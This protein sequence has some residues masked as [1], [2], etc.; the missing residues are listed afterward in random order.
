MIAISAG[1][2]NLAKGAY[3]GDFNEHDEAVVWAQMLVNFLGD[4][5]LLV[6][7]GFLKNKVSYINNDRSIVLAVEIHFNSAPGHV[8]RGSE[9]LCYPSSSKGRHAA[10]TVQDALGRIFQPSRGVKEG[11]YRMDPAR[12]PDFFLART[13]CTA[14]I[15]EPEF[16]HHE[17]AI[18]KNREVACQALTGALLE[19]ASQL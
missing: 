11:Y 19:A 7:F 17:I 14:L 2:H 13:R 18:K 3:Y 10:N 6:P 5:G 1:H 4:D 8:G 12:G 16:V 15:I 9:T